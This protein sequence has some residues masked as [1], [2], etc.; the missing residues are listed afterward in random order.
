MRPNLVLLPS[1]IIKITSAQFILGFMAFRRF[2]Q[3]GVIIEH[4]LINVDLVF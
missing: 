1:F 3:F 2:L 4:N